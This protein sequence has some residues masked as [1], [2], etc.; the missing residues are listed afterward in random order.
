MQITEIKSTL[1]LTIQ[2]SLKNIFREKDNLKNFTKIE[3]EL[4]VPRDPSH[5]DFT[6]N[7]ALRFAKVFREKP[8]DLASRLN[9]EIKKNLEKTSLK[10]AIRQTEATSGGFI[11]FCLTKDFL[12]AE[13]K[14]IHKSGHSFGGEKKP[15][16]KK[17]NI[18]FVSANPTGPLTVAH[19][20]QAACGDAL[21][22]ILTFLGYHVTK[23]YFVNDVGT[24]ITLLGKSIHARYLELNGMEGV[25]P[26]GGYQGEYIKEI[27]QKILDKYGRRFIKDTSEET[28][29]I[30]RFGVN[31]ILDTIKS[32]LGQFGINFDAWFHQSAISDKTINAVLEGLK[33][34]GYVYE[35][36]GAR[37]F[38]STSFGDDKDRVLVK[39][40]GNFTYLAPDIAYHLNKYKRHYA[41]L[42][43]IWGPDHHGYIPRIKAAVQALGYSDDSIDLLIVQLATL[44]RNGVALSMS[45]RKGEFLTLKEVIEEVG[46]DV[47][48]FFFLMRKLDSHLDFDLELAK[49][50]SQDNPVYYIQY[51]HAR[52]ASIIGFSK[53]IEAKLKSQKEDLSALDRP[54]E[55]LLLRTLCRFPLTVSA[56]ARTL[57]PY[58]IVEYLNELAKIF[59]SFYTKHRVVSEDNPELTAARLALVSG[60]KT[61]LANGLDLLGVS[62]PE[63]M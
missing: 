29:F 50:Q 60:V 48:K 57:E 52:I 25:L 49:S 2:E 46:S 7:A 12:R 17:I 62:F 11:N 23:E 37:W 15:G 4:E 59:H 35:K 51:A 39:S 30:A 55:V 53:K 34:K 56:A 38:K 44:F 58:R 45:T 20:R 21:A 10:S 43:D 13:L 19:G 16:G 32:D 61:V 54:E 47:A 31:Y 28:A 18:E 27:A 6:T 1:S 63:R 33:K 22:R 14:N 9:E 5:G 36:D 3:I 41:R 40:D 42:I 8:V 26:E 24:Q